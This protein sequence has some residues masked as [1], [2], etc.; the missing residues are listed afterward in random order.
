MRLEAGKF[1]GS[2]VRQR[3]IRGFSLTSKEYERG[4]QIPLHSHELAHFCLVVDGSY[5]EKTQGSVRDCYASTL[6]FYPPDTVHSEKHLSKGRHF[7]I[8][9][10]AWRWD[11][12]QDFIGQSQCCKDY[13]ARHCSFGLAT[14][15]YKEFCNPDQFSDL[16]TEGIAL[17][18]LVDVSREKQKTERRNRWL[19]IVEKQIAQSLDV[20]WSL[21]RLAKDAGIHPAHLAR[22]FRQVHGCT[23]GEYIRKLRVEMAWRKIVASREPLARIAVDTGFA[24][25]SHFSRSFKRVMGV[26]PGEFQGIYH[27][28]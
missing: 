16:A 24:D 5:E 28:R 4:M 8:E 10:K 17:D 20:S 15:L 9:I 25:Q 11:D 21:E 3:E 6:I 2:T 19:A 27:K 12:V 14:R 13:V 18:L 22:V 1:F 23:V 26:T 7:L